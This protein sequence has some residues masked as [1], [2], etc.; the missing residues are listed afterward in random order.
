MPSPPLKTPKNW[1]SPSNCAYNRRHVLT[2]LPSIIVC[3]WYQN[4]IFSSN[5]T[6]NRGDFFYFLAI[7]YINSRK[8]ISYPFSVSVIR[9]SVVIY[10]L[11][12]FITVISFA[13][14]FTIVMK[15]R[16]DFAIDWV[17]YLHFKTQYVFSTPFSMVYETL[18]FP[19][20]L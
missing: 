7:Y 12:P 8:H 1:F 10:L 13:L 6:Y 3:F 16:I 20:A 14:A 15:K 5:C 11:Y 18:S 9:I 2:F 19:Y 4:L 17:L